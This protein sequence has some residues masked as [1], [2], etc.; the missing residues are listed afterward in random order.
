MK[1]MLPILLV[2][3]LL[4]GCTVLPDI[5]SSY[6]SMSLQPSNTTGNQTTSRLPTEVPSVPSAP[7]SSAIAVPTASSTVPTM[8]SAPTVPT[9]TTVPSVPTTPTTVPPTTAPVPPTTTLPPRLGQVRL[10][11]CDTSLLEAYALIAVRYYNTTGIAVILMAPAE[12]ETCAEALARYM[13]SDMPPTVFCVHEETTL[14]QYAHKMYDLKGTAVA[15]KLYSEDFGMYSGEKLL[16]LPVDVDWF[17]YVYNTALLGDVSFSRK[18]FFR[19]D[20]TSYNSMAYIR[21]YITSQKSTLGAYPFGKP[22]LS[23]TADTGLAAM[24]GKVFTDPDQ[25]R[26]FLDL[27]V[28]NSRSTTDAM[29]SFKDGK[30]VF[31]A[32]TTACFDDALTLGIDKLELLP[33]FAQGSSAMH[34][35]CDHFWAVGVAEYAPDLAETLTFLNWM[36]TAEE[37]VSAPIDALGLLSPF[38]DAAA[39]DNALEKLLRQYMAQEPARLLWN[40]SCVTSEDFAA[41]CAALNAYYLKPNDTNWAAVEAL[42]N[43]MENV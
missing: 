29:A 38:R 18:D 10:Y 41:F 13:A 19:K 23:N 26:S 27:Y 2:L 39:A 31:Y 30:I 35:T 32:G 7:S 22:D 42:M 24:L 9:V 8:P 15:G 37:D 3:L 1:K 43:K 28:S 21:K 12:G 40:E 14:Q 6:P 17:G 33:A 20:M 34:Y 25:L 36:V 4:V 16:A 11:T 5:S